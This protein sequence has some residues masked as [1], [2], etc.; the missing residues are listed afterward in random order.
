MLYNFFFTS[1]VFVQQLVAK[2]AIRE[3]WTTAEIHLRALPVFVLLT[4][5]LV[6]NVYNLNTLIPKYIESLFIF[7]FF[8]YNT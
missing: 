1:G 3:Y 8:S 7:I 6:C 2:P 4:N 5:A